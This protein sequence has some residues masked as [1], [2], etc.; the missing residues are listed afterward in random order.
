MSQNN[1]EFYIITLIVL[2][3]I[4]SSLPV[5]GSKTFNQE[6]L[7]SLNVFL[8]NKLAMTEQNTLLPI[9]SQ[10]ENIKMDV[11]ATAYSSTIW[12]TD[13]TPFVTASQTQVRDGIIAN[14]L[15]PFNTRVKIPELYGDKIFVV[16][17]RMHYL[18][19][20]YQIDLWFPSREEATDFGVKRTYIEVLDN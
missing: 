19:S 6:E 7:S 12:E 8:T 11:I 1:K 9:N 5:F 2:G 18:K 15:L 14:N 13:D 10:S 16:E 20:P 17:D 3:I 4:I